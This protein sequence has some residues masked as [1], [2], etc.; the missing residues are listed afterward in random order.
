MR[1]TWSVPLLLAAACA[2]PATIKVVR[3]HAVPSEPGAFDVSDLDGEPETRRY[4][5]KPE[6]LLA[7]GSRVEFDG[8]PSDGTQVLNPSP[9][10][11]DLTTQTLAEAVHV[12]RAM[13]APES[14]H[15]DPRRAIYVE[16][17]EIVARHSPSV[18]AQV[19][20]LFE[21]LKAHRRDLVRLRV[22]LINLP[23]YA[24][25]AIQHL[26][27][28]REGLGGVVDL[29]DLEKFT[30]KWAEDRGMTM[31][32]V[33]ILTLHH[34]QTGVVTLGSRFAYIKAYE[35][36]G[37]A[38]D[39]VI[40]VITT[41][42]QIRA[43]AVANGPGSDRTVLDAT[44]EVQDLASV[45]AVRLAEYWL[46][47]PRTTT[48]RASGRFVLGPGQAAVMLVPRAKT[49]SGISGRLG[50]ES[51]GPDPV[52]LVVLEATRAE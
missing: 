31:T 17:D 30:P 51:C 23:A 22:R 13:V 50:D 43:N 21:T 4:K 32:G 41:G 1:V 28:L 9:S 2:A 34:A 12:V 45:N 20:R 26:G 15:A 16:R 10:I 19:E 48:V 18:L 7:S 38:F 39:P 44:A 52:T 27:A 49:L 35:V 24:T 36:N 25:D 8:R 5:I 6:D 37:P 3:I 40:D 33:P 46:Q 42:L 29:V 14:W 11:E 47:V